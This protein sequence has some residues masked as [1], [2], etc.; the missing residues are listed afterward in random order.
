[1]WEAIADPALQG[2]G[3]VTWIVDL[4]RQSLDRVIPGMKARRLMQ[5]F[6][7]SGWHVVEAKYGRR[8]QEAFAR[9]GGAAL[10]RHIDDMSN[11]EYQS[12]FAF[13]GADLRQRFLAHADAAVGAARTRCPTTTSAPLV[14]NLGGHDLGEL[15]DATGVRRRHRSPEHR[16][17]LHG[18][19]M[20]AA[21]R[22]RPA[23]PRRPALA[24]QIEAF[25]AGAGLTPETEW[26]RFAA[27]TPEA[28]AARGSAA[29]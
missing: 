12:L 29:R 8:L 6:D 10:R 25:R 21:H 26:D 17:G 4:N 13:H 19:G 11:E 22:R 18:E 23:Q 15:I 28:R 14:Q 5:F 16:V 24:G 1:M 27:G 2:L 20:G 7:E 3:N 9:P